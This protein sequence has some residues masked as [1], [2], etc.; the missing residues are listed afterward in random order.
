MSLEKFAT[1]SAGQ[2]FGKRLAAMTSLAWILFLNPVQG[3]AQITDELEPCIEHALAG[4]RK[5][6]MRL[7]RRFPAKFLLAPDTAQVQFT[8]PEEGCVGFLAVGRRQIQELRLTLYS[9]TGDVL[10]TGEEHGAYAY[11]RT[12]MTDGST[13]I[14]HVELHEGSGEVEILPLVSAP[15]T[16]P[17]LEDAMG[18]CA[19]VGLPRSSTVDVGPEPIGPPLGQRLLKVVEEVKEL[20]YQPYGEP[21]P[22]MLSAMRRELRRI[23][24]PVNTCMA[25]ALVPDEDMGT[26]DFR[27]FTAE[28]EPQLMG[29]DAGQGRPVIVKLCTEESI[30]HIADIRTYDDGGRYLIQVFVIQAPPN[31][32]KIPGLHSDTRI[33]YWEI[34]HRLALVGMSVKETQWVQLPA[35]GEYRAPL[36][37]EYGPCYAIAAF[38]SSHDM[39]DDVDLSVT[40]INGNL[41]SNDTGPELVPLVYVCPT[42]ATDYAAFLRAPELARGTRALLVLAAGK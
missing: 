16:L 30:E 37:L 29:R 26:V 23:T 24:L 5:G 4:A 22:G 41:L 17:G 10:A 34:Q 1:R 33:A 27:L 11:A 40:D 8:L 36:K 42:K 19:G 28:E 25:L 18:E 14:A 13:V 39:L 12:C 2:A 9:D 6:G 35:R 21:I 32:A 31:S 20:G 15:A 7:A 3:L 38:A